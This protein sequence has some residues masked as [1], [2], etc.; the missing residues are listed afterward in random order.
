MSTWSPINIVCGDRLADALYAWPQD[1]LPPTRRIRRMLYVFKM[2]NQ[3]LSIKYFDFALFP[4]SLFT[5][6]CSLL[7][8]RPSHLEQTDQRFDIVL[9]GADFHNVDAAL[10]ESIIKILRLIPGSFHEYFTNLPARGINP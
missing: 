9:I 1:R 4:I 8:S 6:H 7:F 2:F 10:P 3:E 5:V